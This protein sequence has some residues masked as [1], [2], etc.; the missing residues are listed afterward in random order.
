MSTRSLP[1]SPSLDHLR[2]EARDLQRLHRAGDPAAAE[3]IVAHHPRASR[4][5]GTPLRLADAQ[6]VIAR[7]Y[8]FPSW[9][10]LKAHVE[11]FQL[12]PQADR[13]IRENDLPALQALLRAHPGLLKEDIRSSNWGRP[14]TYAAQCGHLAMVKWLRTRDRGDLQHALSRAAMWAHRDVMDYL[15]SEG[16]DPAGPYAEGAGERYGPV[17]LAVYEVQ[18]PAGMRAL[19]EMGAQITWTD[20]EGKTVSPLPMLLAT[21]TR[22]PEG[23]HA[24]LEVCAEFGLT[25]PDTAPMALHQG[26]TDLLEEHL[27]RDPALLQRR[28]SDAEIYPPELGIKPGDGLTT[29]PLDGATLLHMAIEFDDLKTAAWLLERGAD[30]NATTAVDAEG[31][32]GYTPLF[33]AVLTLG[34]KGDAKA[35]LLLDAGADPNARASLR[36]QLKDMGEPEMERERFFVDVTPVAFA[37]KYHWRP[38]VAEAAVALVRERG[39]VE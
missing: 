3:R 16:A 26:R 11:M 36:K 10:K 21:Y 8:G 1:E 9:P 27:R 12:K 39:G 5:A 35:R 38:A 2:Q 18:N 37:E 29:T 15:V 4:L 20:G 19:L 22:N 30:P 34:S 33:H 13:A 6:L 28:F 17:I 32:G 23:K 31:F 14:I 25:L 24:C 7:E